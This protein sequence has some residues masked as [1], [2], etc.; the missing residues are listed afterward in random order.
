MQKTPFLVVQ[1]EVPEN[2]DSGTELQ[3]LGSALWRRGAGSLDAAI[4]EVKRL[5]FDP[6][7]SAE[8]TVESTVVFKIDGVD[9]EFRLLARSGQWVAFHPRSDVYISVIG[10]DFDLDEVELVTISDPSPYLTG[11]QMPYLSS[12]RYRRA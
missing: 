2:L 4:D 3:L 8:R 1:S 10:Y 9:T 5:G 6:V 12:A 7:A 11:S